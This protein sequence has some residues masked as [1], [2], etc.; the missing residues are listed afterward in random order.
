MG[1]ERKGRGSI[2]QGNNA[3]GGWEREGK[4]GGKACVGEA[5]P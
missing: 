5:D 4:V 2:C 1:G 3:E